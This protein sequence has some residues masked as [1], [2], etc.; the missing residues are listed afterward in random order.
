ME[1]RYVAIYDT[2]HDWG[3]FK[4]YSTH[5]AESKAN[6][7]DARRESYKTYGHSKNIVQTYLDKED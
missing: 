1:R 2:G 6:Y 4:F 5:R 7:E 3:T